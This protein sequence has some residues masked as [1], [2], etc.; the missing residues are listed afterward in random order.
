QMIKE[1]NL[2]QFLDAPKLTKFFPFTK[3]L[4]LYYQ[5]GLYKG[6]KLEQWL[7]DKLATKNIFTFNDIEND[8]LKVIVSDLTLGKLVVIPD[9]LHRIYGI[10][11]GTFPIAKAVRMSAGFP[12]FFMPKKISGKNNQK[13]IIVDGGLLSNF[14]LWVF[15]NNDK[16]LKR[17]ILG[18][19][20]TSTNEEN[21]VQ[22]I[23]NA[24]TMFYALF[25][26]MKLA[27]DERY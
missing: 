20:L 10:D 25:S 18:I 15:E 14:P 4:F 21:H 5:I 8:Y 17:P 23:K 11:S 13:S 6:E 3:W 24:F 16:T 26:T 2:E 22:T 7:Y 19:T 27:H 9:D 12:Y 1:L